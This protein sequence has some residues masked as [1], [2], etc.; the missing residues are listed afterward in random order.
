MQQQ[1]QP[2]DR[3]C[4]KWRICTRGPNPWIQLMLMAQLLEGL[5]KED[6]DAGVLEDC[7]PPPSL[8]YT[9]D[10]CRH[11]RFCKAG[12]AYFKVVVYTYY[13][14]LDRHPDLGALETAVRSS[15]PPPFNSAG[16][17]CASPGRTPPSP[18]L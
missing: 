16:P 15:P 2:Y 5:Q 1:R 10:G 7:G 9:I 18:G 6:K 12:S 17:I 4:T 13:P 3:I 11:W 14:I 8:G